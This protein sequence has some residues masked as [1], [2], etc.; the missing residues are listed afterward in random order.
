MAL[1]ESPDRTDGGEI[2]AVANPERGC[3]FLKEGKT[4]LRSEPGEWGVLPA[5][6]ELSQ[7]VPYYEGQIR[8]YKRFPGEQ[9]EKAIAPTMADYGDAL[10]ES[11]GYQAVGEATEPTAVRDHTDAID[12]LRDVPNDEL[13]EGWLSRTDPPLEIDRHLGRLGND[14]L[15]ERPT[16]QHLGGMR[17]ARAHDLLMWVGESYYPEPDDFITECRSHGLSK[18]VPTSKNQDPPVILKG[19]TRCW[20]IHPNAVPSGR[21]D[22]GNPTFEPGLVGYAYVTRVIH[23]AKTV[24]GEPKFPEWAEAAAAA[25]K[26]DL[27]KI[28]ERE[29]AEAHENGSTIDEWNGDDETAS[30]E[31]SE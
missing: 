5:F 11:D 30:T 16:A 4:Y 6:V 27:V 17:T 7:P 29:P 13:G 12:T 9:F 24:N 1:A 25:G 14:Y 23:T 10:V 28:G 3:G 18:A 19:R 20:V 26:M 31:G 2:P 22:D 15:L 8:G 21:D